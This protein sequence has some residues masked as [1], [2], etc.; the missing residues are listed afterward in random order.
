MGIIIN[1]ITSRL[2]TAKERITELEDEKCVALLPTEIQKKE[3]AG[4]TELRIKEL[5]DKNT[6][7]LYNWSVLR[8]RNK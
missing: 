4:G 6:E 2:D 1:G 5:R 8:K 3:R 7:H